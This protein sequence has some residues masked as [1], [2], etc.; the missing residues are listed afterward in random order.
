[1]FYHPRERACKRQSLYSLSVHGHAFGS[2]SFSTGVQARCTRESDVKADS[3]RYKGILLA[4]EKGYTCTKEGDVYS[5]RGNKLKLR[6]DPKRG[7]VGYYV[8]GVRTKNPRATQK[9]GVHQF[10]AYLKYGDEILNHECVR[11][12]DSNSLNNHWDNIALGSH[13]D[14]AMDKPAEDRLKYALNAT[15]HM[16]KHCNVDEIKRFHAIGRSY[17][18][19]MEKFGISSKGT[20]NYILNKSRND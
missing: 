11:H 20:L 6:I 2:S 18:K 8:F 16:K 5:S 9:I 13:S 7:I 17:K 12:L 4:V 15:S 19:T 3:K 1:M 10:Q 14:N